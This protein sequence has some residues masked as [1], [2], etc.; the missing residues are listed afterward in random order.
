MSSASTDRGIAA[1]PVRRRSSLRQLVF[2]PLAVALFWLC[3]LSVETIAQDDPS[4]LPPPPQK[5]ASKEERNRLS[6][7]RDVKSRTKI[8]IEL[9]NTRLGTAEKLA[10]AGDFEGMSGE[11]GALE[12]I[13][14]LHLDFLI[15]ND[16]DSNR[17]LDNFKRFE[18]GLRTFMPRIETVRRDLPLRYEPY[19]RSVGKYIRN[20]RTRALEPLFGDT[21]VREPNRPN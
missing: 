8:A 10:A 7:E 9:M 12:A 2:C 21:V 5:I 13:L 19:V 16:N 14:D 11:L 18:I 4:D 3:L 1:D 15:K 17:V 20:A 6:A